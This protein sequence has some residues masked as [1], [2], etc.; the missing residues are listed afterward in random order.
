MNPAAWLGKMI[1]SCLTSERVPV[2][3]P[4]CDFDRLRYEVRPGDVILVEGRSRVSE[5]IR[6]VTQSPWSHSALYIGR[7]HD[8]DDEDL[9]AKVRSFYDGDPR[10]QLV[11]EA[12]L[13]KGT[14]VN[15]LEK[16]HCDTLR[17]CRPTGLSRQD[18]QQV[19]KFAL[20]HLGFEYD[21]RQLLDLARFLFPYSIIPRQWRSSLFEHNAGS[22]TRSVCSSMIA[23]AFASVRFP[24]L[25]VLEKLHDG[26]LRLIPRN[27]RLFTP[28]DFD[29]SPYFDII[30]CP[31]TEFSMNLSYRDL[32]WDEQGRICNAHGD[33][34]TPS[35]HP[36]VDR[37]ADSALEN[38]IPKKVHD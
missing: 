34:Y 5:I 20:Q 6:T 37:I 24:V 10:E 30:K 21:L 26:S 28:R 15:P 35:L 14:I 22:P 9:C 25:P 27:T 8:I 19:M 3:P 4:L 23:A 13:G 12:W 1:V 31:H 38:A 7:I 33:C 36:D 18:A 2:Q 32:P 11:V 17:I 16:Y 29:Y